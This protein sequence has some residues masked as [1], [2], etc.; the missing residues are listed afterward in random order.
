M[1]NKFY[2]DK[3]LKNATKFGYKGKVYELKSPRDIGEILISLGETSA[4]YKFMEANDNNQVVVGKN[5]FNKE[6]KS[7]ISNMKVYGDNIKKAKKKLKL[8]TTAVILTIALAAGALVGCEKNNQKQEE[9][10]EET[11]NYQ[12]MDFEQLL[13][14]LN[15]GVQH[16]SFELMDE[17]QDYFNN[18]AAPTIKVKK[19]K[20]TQ[21]FLNAE[22]IKSLFIYANADTYSKETF[23]E[24]FGST[25]D[26][27]KATEDYTNSA[28]VLNNYYLRA[29]EKSGI[30]KLFQEEKNQ[31][32]FASFEQ[33]VLNYNKNPNNE[34]K[35]KIVNKL[36]QIYFSGKIDSLKNTCPE[37]VSFIGTHMTAALELNGVLSKSFADKVIEANETVTCN[38]IK[39]YIK[40]IDE[41]TEARNLI[42]TTNQENQEINLTD[43][44]ALY[45]ISDAM[46]NKNIKVSSRDIAPIIKNGNITK[47]ISTTNAV[48]KNTK[49][50]NTTFTRKKVSKK[51]AIKEFGKTEVTKAE[52]K[53]DKTDPIITIDDKDFSIDDANEIEE[54]TRAAKQY[55]VDFTNDIYHEMNENNGSFNSST[56]ENKITDK[57][58]SYTGKYKE[59]YKTALW[60]GYKEAIRLAKELYDSEKQ[61]REE[62]AKQVI[63]EETETITQ[64]V[65]PQET[66]DTTTNTTTETTTNTTNNAT[67]STTTETT[68]ETITN[69]NETTTI[70]KETQTITPTENNNYT[71]EE[72]TI[73]ERVYT[74]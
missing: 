52:E 54:I 16:D 72:E 36:D 3:E 40:E 67:N 4:I 74:K 17:V 73:I 71:Y 65:T 51:T 58:N 24:I 50:K 38:T 44:Q 55:G 8:K 61:F 31:E 70:T 39:E 49:I 46:D 9:P 43:N 19:D 26:D 59:K 29:T 11:L 23:Y 66:Q 6:E 5:Y 69:N 62:A 12:E 20:D 60:Q 35:Q 64:R 18:T 27:A 34:N 56:Y 37:A 10:V 2:L 57:A 42:I 48:Y 30:D 41:Y 1:D 63:K 15:E 13:A 68:T 7:N 25:F 33:L 32:L 22:E 47:K 21:L 14:L 53:S 45:Y 28:R